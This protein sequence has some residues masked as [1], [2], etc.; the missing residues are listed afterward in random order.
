M[1]AKPRLAPQLQADIAAGAVEVRDEATRS[2]LT[3]PAD[4]LFAA[5]TAR[6]DASRLDLLG[7]IARTL[8]PLPG[9]V[10]VVGHTDGAPV[11]S[12]QFPSNWHL[13]RERA[14]A[15]AAALVQQGLQAD[16]VRAEGRADAEPRAAED[17]PAGRTMNR[18]IE[19]ELLL[20]RPDA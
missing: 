2:V 6:L 5:G 19:I 15:V 8:R 10:V 7:R 16:R 20:P 14:Q 17:T 13:S 9:V 12:L 3:L 4:L 18:R 1:A 11:A